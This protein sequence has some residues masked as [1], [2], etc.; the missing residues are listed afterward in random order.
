MSGA[1][2]LSFPTRAARIAEAERRLAVGDP[3][4]PRDLR[5]AMSAAG[6]MPHRAPPI[7]AGLSVTDPHFSTIWENA[8]SLPPD[9]RP[10]FYEM[11]AVDLKSAATITDD[12][13]VAAAIQRAVRALIEVPT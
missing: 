2:L 12:D 10:Q 7:A 9:V 8:L 5:L 3:G 4:L 6:H 13:D 1:N 11:V